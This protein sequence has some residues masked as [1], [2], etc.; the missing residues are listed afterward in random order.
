MSK[1]GNAIIRLTDENERLKAT[2]AE[3][4]AACEAVIGQ[5]TPPDAN[6]QWVIMKVESAIKRA[7]ESEE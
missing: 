6:D 1:Q 5:F 4:L 2:N 3:L 7:K